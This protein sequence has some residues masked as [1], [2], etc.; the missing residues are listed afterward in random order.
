MTAPVLRAGRKSKSP[1]SCP[2]LCESRGRGLLCTFQQR[3][4]REP[5]RACCWGFT[6]VL[7]ELC[8]L[9]YSTCHIFVHRYILNSWDFLLRYSVFYRTIF[10]IL[11]RSYLSFLFK[12][13]GS[14]IRVTDTLGSAIS[15]GSLQ[16]PPG[17]CP[18]KAKSRSSASTPELCGQQPRVVGRQ[19]VPP[20][21]HQSGL[22]L[23]LPS[24]RPRSFQVT[25]LSKAP[26][27]NSQAETS[28]S[29]WPSNCPHK[30][31]D[32]PSH[33]HKHAGPKRSAGQRRSGRHSPRNPFR[34]LPAVT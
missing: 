24:P 31:W 13:P 15:G 22:R 9:L 14:V 19:P 18:L 1:Q 21:A 12:K 32:S 25:P 34:L 2:G 8:N 26:V 33:V 23:P 6:S 27:P 28:R 20:S 5:L 16:R 4:S 10:I 30:R 29:S 17:C 11:E 7:P 3:A